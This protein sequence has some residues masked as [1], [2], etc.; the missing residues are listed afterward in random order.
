M[1]D[2]GQSLHRA[3]HHLGK[4]GRLQA[5]AEH[6][7]DEHRGQALADGEDVEEVA[8]HL[9]DFEGG[10]VG[11]GD[12]QTGDL[13]H[14]P[15]E[16][17]AQHVGGIV[18]GLV[19]AAVFEGQRDR[20]GELGGEALVGLVDGA[21]RRLAVG[22]GQQP[23]DPA[24]GGERRQ[25][26]GADG[27][28]AEQLEADGV[29]VQRVLDDDGLLA[30]QLRPD[31]LE[32]VDGLMG[33]D[34]VA[35]QTGDAAGHQVVALAQGDGGAVGAHGARRVQDR[36]VDDA[37]EVARRVHRRVD[38]VERGVHLLGLAA[39]RVEQG[40]VEGKGD[41]D[42][43]LAGQSHRHLVALER[44]R[45]PVE[46]QGGDD[47]VA[48]H[49]RHDELRTDGVLE[50]QGLV[51]PRVGE[52][53]GHRDR[54]AARGRGLHQLIVAERVA[55]HVL[56]GAVGEAQYPAAA[57]AQHDRRRLGAQGAAGF[58]HHAP[59]DLV[60]V[61]RGADGDV[62]RVQGLAQPAGL[63]HAGQ[64]L[65]DLVDIE[66]GQDRAVDAVV[67]GLVGAHVH[68]IPAAGLVAHLA[69]R[70]RHGL[71]HPDEHGLQVG[72]VDLELQVGDGPSDVAGDDVEDLFG[73]RRK[74]PDAQVA[75]DDDEGHVDAVEQ[76]GQV[77][78]DKAQLGVAALQLIVDGDELLVGRLQLL[79]GRLELFVD[80][81]Q[82]LHARLDLLVG[83]AQLLVGRLLVFDHV[84]Q[85]AA[86]VDQLLA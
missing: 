61:E 85:V 52:G 53:V 26:E 22:K 9:L 3:A 75:P 54:F 16:L 8:A 10:L 5:A 51:G 13:R 30:A 7:G 45:V 74:A 48:A 83:G 71:D 65:L 20:A 25:H 56:H 60:G 29:G 47:L 24:L 64:V 19:Q 11:G 69:L 17:V 79:L 73:A 37:V 21:G 31:V 39:L 67:G 40:V 35:R 28:A 46:E 1:V 77:V 2:V 63:G 38:D 41:R 12:V 14:R 23:D 72:N 81:L 82:L 15:H 43:E 6:V 49:Q 27:V 84:L 57:F 34:D 70:R 50:D 42:G 59:H 86:R 62:H 36:G 80:A 4:A 58:D 68:G 55:Q 18:L 66:Q 78:V 44:V 33:A 76:V 32:G